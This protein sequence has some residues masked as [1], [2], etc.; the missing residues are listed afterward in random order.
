M[1]LK[2]NKFDQ[3]I[4]RLRE[5]ISKDDRYAELSSYLNEIKRDP[6][7]N[8]FGSSELLA[9][10]SDRVIA[11][12]AP[13]SFKIALLQAAE[14]FRTV[15]P[16]GKQTPD[17]EHRCAV[18]IWLFERDGVFENSL[19]T[20][21]MYDIF[22]DKDIYIIVLIRNI[23]VPGAGVLLLRLMP[24]DPAIVKICCLS[25]SMPIAALS[26]MLAEQH[27]RK[28]NYCNKMIA[29]STVL[30]VVTVPLLSLLYL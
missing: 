27:A 23:L 15:V 6:D 10:I 25:A 22:A 11:I 5:L 29:M 1:A 17:Y 3:I 16:L 21:G 12:N 13:G 9:E 7:S 19:I 24:F 4:D 14:I 26:G 8:P 30:S 28:G 18:F 20:P 2:K